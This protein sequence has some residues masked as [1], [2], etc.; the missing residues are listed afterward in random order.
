[1][2]S[3]DITILGEDIKLVSER[4]NYTTLDNEVRFINKAFIPV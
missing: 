4:L 3:F 2:E 1:M